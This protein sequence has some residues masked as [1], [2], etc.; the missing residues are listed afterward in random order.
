MPEY[1]FELRGWKALAAIVALLGYFLVQVWLRV[2]PVDDRMRDAVRQELLNEYSG[3]GPKDVARM[4]ANLRE[5]E[6]PEPIPDIVPHVIQ[7][8]SVSAHGRVGGSVTLVRVELTVDGG[9][10]PDGK[11]IR[12]FEVSHQL[13]RSWLVVGQSSSYWYYRMLLP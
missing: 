12:Y 1:K 4:V 8:N 7:F 2:Q 3:R 10:P 13:D 9:V 5:G 6:P 11:P